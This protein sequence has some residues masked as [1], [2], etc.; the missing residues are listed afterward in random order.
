MGRTLISWATEAWNPIVGCSRISPGCRNCYAADLPLDPKFKKLWQY[1]AVKKWDGTIAFVKKELY[2][3]FRWRNPRTAFLSVTDIAHENVKRN[4]LSQVL[5]VMALTPTH[6]YKLLTKRP[7]EMRH[8]FE[9]LTTTELYKAALEFWDQDLISKKA[10]RSLKELERYFSE[11]VLPLPNVWRGVSVENQDYVWRIDELRHIQAAGNFISCEP[12]LGPVNLTPY[13]GI[14]VGCQSCD[15][16]GG[17]R[18]GRSVVDWVIA[19]GESTRKK[20][21]SRPC[22]VDWLRSIVSQCQLANIP[23]FVKQLGSNPVQFQ[24]IQG[25]LLQ[26]KG[27]NIIL[28][29]K[30]KHRKGTDENE[31]PIDLQGCQILPEYHRVLATVSR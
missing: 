22:N 15:F 2:R 1:Q 30:T 14:C 11:L 26:S 21:D 28:P 23:P 9:T 16:R 10:W 12:L 24:Y 25:N 27:D 13:L 17:H 29:Y 4:E 31:F 19:G 18:I 20:S 5:A 8:Y 7:V 6:I 3:P